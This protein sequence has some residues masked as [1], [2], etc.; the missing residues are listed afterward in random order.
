MMKLHLQLRPDTG[1]SWPENLTIMHSDQGKD[2]AVKANMSQASR[3]HNQQSEDDQEFFTARAQENHST[4]YSLQ[5]SLNSIASGELSEKLT[6]IW[7]DVTIHL[8]TLSIYGSWRCVR[9]LCKPT[10]NSARIN[11]DYHICPASF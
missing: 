7:L 10:R 11:G 6:I 3:R 8:A 1:T 5:Q 4:C 2:S 9:T